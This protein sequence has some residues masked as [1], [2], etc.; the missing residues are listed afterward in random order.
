MVS[1]WEAPGK[2]LFKK[3]TVKSGILHKRLL[4][5]FLA[6]RSLFFIAKFRRV[7]CTKTIKSRLFKK[8]LK[9]NTRWHPFVCILVCCYVACWNKQEA[10]HWAHPTSFGKGRWF[11]IKFVNLVPSV[12][13]SYVQRWALC[14]KHPRN[15]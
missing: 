15:V 7:F 9:I 3:P 14:S 11:L 8:Y 5:F 1:T 2:K 10:R 12:A 6:M 4:V 13:A